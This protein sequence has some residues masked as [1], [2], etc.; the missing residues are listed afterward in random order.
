MTKSWIASI[1]ALAAMS[2]SAHA[3]A[4]RSAEAAAPPV[5]KDVPF[6]PTSEEVV[7][8]M[9]EL[10]NVGS[11]DVLY[12]LGSGD[13]RIVIAATRDYGARGVGVDIDPERI[14]ESR[15]NARTAGVQDRVLPAVSQK[16]KPRLL[17]ELRP[18]T[19][20]VSHAFD[21]GEDWPPHKTI[22]V[23]GSTLCLWVIPQR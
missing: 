18:G 5:E 10:A 19:R 23:D 17:K 6:V 13:G 3:L 7:D 21:M 16:L 12:D 15:A 22:K 4:Q 8:G 1:A 14:A 2:W 9:L 20:V 11:R